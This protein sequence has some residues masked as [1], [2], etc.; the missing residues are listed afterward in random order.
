[1]DYN[2]GYRETIPDQTAIEK[3]TEFTLNTGRKSLIVILLFVG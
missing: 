2:L 3:W 1:M